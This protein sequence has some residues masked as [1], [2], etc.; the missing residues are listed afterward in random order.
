[1]TLTDKLAR[2]WINRL[3]LDFSDVQDE[4]GFGD[5]MDLWKKL[6]P[7]VSQLKPAT[8]GIITTNGKG[9]QEIGIGEISMEGVHCFCDGSSQPNSGTEILNWF[10][11]TA[12][13][14]VIYK[15]LHDQAEWDA[16]NETHPE[17]EEL[18]QDPL[19][20]CGDRYS[21]HYG[22]GG[23]CMAKH[24]RNQCECPEFGTPLD[25]YPQGTEVEFTEGP[26]GHH[27]YE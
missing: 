7:H 16:F 6:Y 3:N 13:I 14:C 18:A 10:A 17:P 23:P 22:D 9:P 20:N 8:K 11:T 24:G 27:G 2:R 4:M 5:T 25:E 21:Q 1:M 15:I 19:C 12:M 26:C